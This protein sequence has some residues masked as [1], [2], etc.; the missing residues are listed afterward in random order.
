[1]FLS[2][3]VAQSVLDLLVTPDQAVLVLL[4]DPG[5][6]RTHRYTIT[7]INTKKTIIYIEYAVQLEKLE[8]MPQ[9]VKESTWQHIVQPFHLARNQDIVSS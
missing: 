5:I 7:R 2:H 8:Q 9:H 6:L 3:L 1:M 4:S